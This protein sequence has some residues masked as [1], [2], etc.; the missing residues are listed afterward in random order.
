MG[1][2]AHI[3]GGIGHTQANG[4]VRI[5]GANSSGAS[6]GGARTS[7]VA[8]P[9]TLYDKAPSGIAPSRIAPSRIAPS[10]IA[11]SGIAPSGIAPSGGASSQ[12][13]V[14]ETYDQRQVTRQEHT[15]LSVQRQTNTTLAEGLN[16]LKTLMQKNNTMMEQFFKHVSSQNVAQQRLGVHPKH[17]VQ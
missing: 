6:S 1:G 5:V 10:G 4:T 17:K 3:Q 12:G 15:L 8:S 11:P 7:G 13:M 9:A 16:E 14:V 2:R